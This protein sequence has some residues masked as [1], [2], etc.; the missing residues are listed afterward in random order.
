MEIYW[1]FPPL[2]GGSKQG[3][4]NNDIE[5]F[6]GEELINN[7]AREICQNS[8]D[9]C[10]D[11]I[12]KPVKVVFELR[13]V[14]TNQYNVFS[15]YNQCLER[16]KKFWETGET[17]D[18]KLATFLKESKNTLEKPY[19]NI[20]I[21]SDYNTK[22]LNGSRNPQNIS[23]PWEALTG[24][25]GVSVKSN[26]NSGGSFG[27]G[28][29]APF[30]CSSLS[31]VFY[32]TWDIENNKAFIGVGKAATLLN[33]NGK[34]TQRVGRYQK[35]DDENEQ[36]EP[37]YEEDSNAFRDLF[38]RQEQGTDII[39]VGFNEIDD[40]QNKVAKAVIKNFFIAILENKLI[41]ETKCANDTILIDN[42]TLPNL[43]KKY[44]ETDPKISIT[45]QF[46]IAYSNP[47]TKESLDILDEKNAAE[48]YIKFEKSFSRNI[49][50]FRSTGMLIT[51]SQRRLTQHYA[52]IVIIR[53]KKLD[54]L[55][56]RCEPP[57]HNK[58]DHKLINKTTNREEYDNAKK[59]IKQL[60]EKL[61]SLLQTR[62]ITQV[63]DITDAPGI[64]P[65]LADPDDE[66][67][68][69]ENNVGEDILRVKIKIGKPKIK[70]QTPPSLNMSGEN[71]KGEKTAGTGG[72]R[73]LRTGQGT[74]PPDSREGPGPGSGP[75]SG[76]NPG[77][78]SDPA[79]KPTAKDQQGAIKGNK[80]RNITVNEFPKRRIFAFDSQHGLYKAV[81]LPPKN[82]KNLYVEC[83]V[84]GED[85]NRETLDIDRFIFQNKEISCTNGKAGPIEVQKNIP[86]E[87]IIT[88][89]KK[90]E[91][92]LNLILSEGG[93]K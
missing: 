80:G 81:I 14:S 41:V 10:N 4:T 78:S 85:G 67:F 13:K 83:T 43:V 21:A 54:E 25:D 45:Q 20:L 92:G 64:A 6:K 63:G 56:R 60:R 30:A 93:S 15:E 55:L 7:L 79:V 82:Y 71:G 51:Q 16:C 44:A 35:N 49:A 53:G 68:A 90:E 70:K 84:C 17:I 66:T 57:K 31:M 65:Y 50:H 88:F 52:A 9:A 39:I 72:N 76:N 47:D 8:L 1:R 69:T 42:T 22:G 33:E 18:A 3:Y 11:K 27:I 2:S 58:W 61:E 62:N 28:K 48:I 24:A 34:P 29:N 59:A 91:M 38:T 26:N 89:A 77:K 32:N 19:I 5:G 86:A 73:G 23:S 40:W 37:I 12:N 87:F 36:W 74:I 75:L 46:F